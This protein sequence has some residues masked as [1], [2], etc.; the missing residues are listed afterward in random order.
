MKR[1]FLVDAENVHVY[2]LSG[3]RD[4][5]KD[6]VVIVFLTN[7]C[8]DKIMD[9]IS[10]YKKSLE[11]KIL[12]MEVNCGSK[13]ALDFQLVSYLGLLIGE[14]KDDDIEYYIVSKDT[15]YV[16]SINLLSNC[17]NNKIKRIPSI[18]LYNV[19]YNYDIDDEIVMLLKYTIKKETKS[20]E[21]LN[22]IKS[23]CTRD[24]A[25]GILTSRYPKETVEKLLPV[26]N[27]YFGGDDSA[28]I[29]NIVMIE[30][31]KNF[32]NKKTVEKIFNI[33]KLT[34]SIDITLDMIESLLSGLNDWRDRIQDGLQVYY[35]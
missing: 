4:L 22:T 16:A 32:K 17:I 26:L 12:T 9:V 7:Q 15:G 34:N 21:I 27:M 25:L 13:N 18:M 14:H 24:H 33:M 2:G 20:N 30:L 28:Y 3:I 29:D 8:G 19:E 23:C 10:N 5:T 6:D 31:N 1:Y 35:N 11:C